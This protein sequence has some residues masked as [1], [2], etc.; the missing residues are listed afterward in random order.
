MKLTAYPQLLR[1]RLKATEDCF[2]VFRK[3]AEEAENRPKRGGIFKIFKVTDLKSLDHYKVFQ[4]YL[5]PRIREIRGEIDFIEKTDKLSSG[6]IEFR[7]NLL[8]R[9]EEETNKR[10]EDTKGIMGELLFGGDLSLLDLAY[11]AINK[12]YLKDA[13]AELEIFQKERAM[14]G[15]RPP[16]EGKLDE[17]KAKLNFEIEKDILRTGME[18][19]RIMKIDEAKKKAKKEAIV[20]FLTR[21]GAMGIEDLSGKAFQELQKQLTNIDELFENAKTGDLE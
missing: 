20:A 13:I 15:G 8:R 6:D 16:Y 14:G 4:E 1:E 21:E 18:A 12:T 7:I 9:Q 5:E 17:M 19:T 11:H 10:A 2:D 3:K